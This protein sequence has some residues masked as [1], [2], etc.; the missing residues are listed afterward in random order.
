MSTSERELTRRERRVLGVLL[1]KGLSTPEYYPMTRKALVSGCNQRNNRDPVTQ[2]S[3]EQ[4]EEALTMLAGKGLVLSVM[5]STGRAERWRQELGKKYDLRAVQLGVIAELLL[6][7]PQAEGELR[8]RASRMRPIADLAELRE[9]LAGLE[10]HDPPLVW[11]LTPE[12]QQ[13]GARHTHAFYPESERQEVARLE[14]GQASGTSASAKAAEATA[15]PPPPSGGKEAE[16][17]QRIRA[18]EDR[19]ARLEARLASPGEPTL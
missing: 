3:E 2:Y 9:L 6:R 16:L 11:R 10:R 7:G 19:L 17:W 18:L 15:T 4:V 14:S 12:G 1:E 13:R 8:A 5:A